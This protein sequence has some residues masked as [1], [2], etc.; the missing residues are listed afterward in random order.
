MRTRHI[1]LLLLAA[2]AWASCDDSTATLGI[3]MLPQ[4]DGIATHT[5]TYTAQSRSVP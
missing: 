2:V 3:D 4:E 5:T 1:G